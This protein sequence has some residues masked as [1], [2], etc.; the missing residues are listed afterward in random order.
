MK[1]GIHELGGISMAANFRILVH[2]SSESLHLKL[3]GDFDETSAQE[4]FCA[5]KKNGARVGR[6]FV[7]T[8]G[9]GTVDPSVRTTVLNN[10]S[11]LISEP[12]RLIFTGE[13]GAKL[14]PEGSR[15]LWGVLT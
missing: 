3:I 12:A 4:L 7:H 13:N 5:L 11:T 8:S 6:I 2:R 9:I 10:L 15:F 1:K 14:V